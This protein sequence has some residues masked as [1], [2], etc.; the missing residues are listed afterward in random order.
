V[1]TYLSRQVGGG[2]SAFIV[3]E[4]VPAHAVVV[5]ERVHDQHAGRDALVVAEEEATERRERAHDD[6]VAA[7]AIGGLGVHGEAITCYRW[8][9]H[10][11]EAG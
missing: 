10:G 4:V 11:R 9:H 7:A 2:A 5:Q 6:G 3:G 8:C 1:T